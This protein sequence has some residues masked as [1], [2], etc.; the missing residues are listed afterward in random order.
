MASEN[1]FLPISALSPDQDLSSEGLSFWRD[2]FSRLKKSRRAKIA[3]SILSF[4]VLLALIGP[5]ISGHT[6]YDINLE[7]K[8]TPPSNLFWL[9][10]DDLGRDLFTRLCYGIRISL[11]VGL[12]A[13]LIDLIIGVTYGAFAAFC[14]GKTD[15]VLMRLIDILSTIPDLLII[16]ALTVV[17][18]TGLGSIILAFIVTGWISMARIIRSKILQ[19]KSADYVLAS[20]TMGAGAKHIFVCHLIPSCIGPMAVMITLS[21]PIAIFTEAILSFLGLGV[22]VPI[23]SLGS[24]AHDGLTSMQYY[25]W[26]LFFP[27]IAISCIIL[28]F[29]VLGDILRDC[30]DPKGKNT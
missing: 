3:L 2:G 11:F 26:R 1:A 21:I 7:I 12:A 18:G 17:F 19:T 16:I 29:N 14:G 25:P 20:K 22:Q 30:F 10:S 27:S 15:E 5:W 6:Y 24:L 8:N 23:A 4:F 28:S 13:A 9:G